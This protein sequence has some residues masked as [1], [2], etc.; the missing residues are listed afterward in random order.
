MDCRRSR[1]TSLLQKNRGTALR[2]TATDA[3]PVGATQVAMWPYEDC[4]AWIAADGDW[5]RSYKKTA[6]L[7]SG[8]TATGNTPVGATQVA[9][10][11]YEDRGAQPAGG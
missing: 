2:T 11:P 1:L 4:G 9:M 7:R 3:A 5:R 6:A 10:W 8:T